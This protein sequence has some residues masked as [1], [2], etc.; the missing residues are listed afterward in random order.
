[1]VSVAPPTRI[2]PVR[3]LPVLFTVTVN[4]SEV[5]PVSELFVVIQ[6]ACDVAVHEQ[7][8]AVLTKLLLELWRAGIVREVGIRL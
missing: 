1:M 7:F 4:V 8:A 5:E 6:E 3:V 2:V